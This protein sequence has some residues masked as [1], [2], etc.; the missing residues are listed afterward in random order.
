DVAPVRTKPLPRKPVQ[1]LVSPDGGDIESPRWTRDGRSILYTH[2][3]PDRDGFGFSQLVMV[4][5]LT[6]DITE[7]DKPSLDVVYSH[8]RVASDGALAYVAHRNGG[9]RL[10]VS[11]EAGPRSP[12]TLA[13]PE[14]N[15]GA[16]LATAMQGGFADIH[17]ITSSGE[18]A[19]TRASGGAFQPAPAPDGRLFFMSLEPEGYALRVIPATSTASETSSILQPPR[20]PV[21]L[22]EQ[23]LSSP[24]E[25]GIGRQ[26]FQPLFSGAVAKS[27]QTIEAGIRIGDVVGRL[28]TIIVGAAGDQRGAAIASVWRGWPVDIG[29]H[30]FRTNA[31]RGAEVRASWS[32]QWPL[33]ALRAGSGY[34]ALRH[35]RAPFATVHAI[36]NQNRAALKSSEDLKLIWQRELRRA[37]AR[38]NLRLGAYRFAAQLDHAT[39]GVTLGG[40]ATTLQPESLLD[41]R[42]LEPALSPVFRDR[43]YTGVRAE[44]GIGLLTLFRQQHRLAGERINVTGLEVAMKSPP[45]P[46]VK[47]PG[48]DLTFGAA[49]VE[50]KTRWWGGVRWRP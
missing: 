29:A 37:I 10:Y 49:R 40:I 23:A 20:E 21:S 26:E 17:R 47:A 44:A 42:V 16:L 8:P 32:A 28:D 45:V 38:G 25:Y 22:T 11:P 5:L 36:A 30:L 19:V 33:F 12:S 43:D 46:W 14:W 27:F 7:R 4:N 24:V 41:Q 34:L 9:W 1:S 18:D 39:R 50:G 31:Q 2:R 48:L 15:A 6:G 35:D 3:Q 13:T